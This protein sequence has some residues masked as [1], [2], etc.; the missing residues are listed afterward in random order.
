MARVLTAVRVSVCAEQTDRWL[1][2]LATLAAR[3]AARGQRVW[4]FRR[5]DGDEWLEFTEG[6][7]EAS[8]RSRGPADASEAA[9]EFALR[10]L[11]RYDDAAA[12]AQW[13][14]VPLAEQ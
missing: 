6:K 2:T 12:T 7:D 9:L 11:A 8:H 1:A 10:S 14:E 4:V 5:D 13:R 3:L